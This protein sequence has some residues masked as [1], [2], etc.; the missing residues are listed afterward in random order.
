MLTT[1]V[2][3]LTAANVFSPTIA[4]EA[5]PTPGAAPTL[6]LGV[7]SEPLAGDLAVAAKT[8]ALSNRVRL[9][10]HPAST[11]TFDVG[12]A[13]RF[14]ASLHYLQRIGDVDVYQ[15]KLVITVDEKSR[16]VQVASSVV[17]GRPLRAEFEMSEAAALHFASKQV[18]FPAL[19]HDDP[20][21][22]YGGAKKVLFPVGDALHAGW[23]VHVASYDPSKNF[24]VGLDAVT[25][26]TLFVQNR[27]HRAE[28][29]LNA[30]A[31]SPGDLDGG[32]GRTPT[33]VRSLVRAGDGGSF[34]GDTCEIFLPDGGFITTSNDAGVL[35]GEQLT[36]YNCCTRANCEADAGPR[37]VAGPTNFMGFMLN[38]DLPVCDRVNQATNQ[39]PEGD[40]RYAPVDPPTNRATVDINDPANSDTFAHV[41]AFYHVNRVYDWVR[42][43]STRGATL[44]PMNQP[45]IGPFRMRDE[46]RMP[47]R[48]PAVLTNVMIPNFQDIQGIPQCLPPPIGQGM[49]ACVVG[50]FGRVDNAAFLPVEQFAQ[51]P[52]PGL[53]TGVDTLMIFQGNAADAAYDATV[54][55][56]EFGHGV[57]YATAALTF[58]DIALDARSANNE[59]GALH[60]G[61]SDYIAAA[62]GNTPDVGPYFGPRAIGAAGV[63]GVRQDSY[64]RTL[65]N[66]LACPD[67]LWGQV[68]NDS[69][70]ISAA[71][72]AGRLAN[73]G[74]DNGATYDAAFYAMLVS[75][76]PNADFAS[77][78]QIM[79]ARVSGAFNAGAGAALTATFQ[80]KGVIG[81][82]KVLD[83]TNAAGPRPVF[84]IP[85]ASMLRNATVPG[86]LQFKLR[87]P[88]GAQGIRI[89]GSQGGGGGFG[90]GAPPAVTILTKAGGPIAFTRNGA[91]LTN[92][93][94]TTATVMAAGG[95]IDSVVPVRVPC[96]ATQEIHVAV[97]ARGGGTTIQSLD[98][99]AEPLVGCMFPVDA[100]MPMPDAGMMEEPDAGPGVTETKM[101]PRAGII[102]QPAAQTGCGCSSFDGSAVFAALALLGL[103]RRRRS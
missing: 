32:V 17:D 51:L 64:L 91:Q 95:N 69:Q 55:W 43:L 45:A 12:F 40:Y 3:M 34:I 72:W 61:L 96:G 47:A 81:C 103:G 74:T 39:R 86:P 5:R 53:S 77:V 54:L 83:V 50:S 37:R 30:Y 18:S 98:V 19:R 2:A 82:S 57:V 13:T 68:H 97:A 101:L 25:G 93:A 8:W 63:M 84:G 76:A 24:Y 71:L 48:K 23:L 41:H 66:T 70:H 42:G 56:H 88:M 1:I 85:A 28:A 102:A 52:I 79:A 10:L 90:G 78:A 58:E 49:G 46:R 11:L 80:A 60:E 26:E 20:T 75:L 15:A 6:Q 29:D 65:S 14:G 27:V 16:V 99:T 59:G 100:G 62:F 38:V 87:V 33:E 35:C 21:R 4:F 7:L 67:V 44:F 89:R 94:E 73:L 92:D 36:T 22:P 9:G 31:I